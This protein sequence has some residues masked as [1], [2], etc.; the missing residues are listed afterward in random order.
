MGERVASL[1]GLLGSAGVRVV[2]RQIVSTVEGSIESILKIVKQNK[3]YLDEFSN[4]LNGAG[5]LVD[6]ISKIPALDLQNFLDQ[7]VIT[8]VFL[9]MRE[10]LG[11]GLGLATES[12]P[13]LSEFFDSV[14]NSCQNDSAGG[15]EV[16][17]SSCGIATAN[18][19]RLKDVIRKSVGK[20]FNPELV[21][22]I[23]VMYA[24]SFVC[25]N[26]WKMS[27]F[28][29]KLNGFA[30]N[31]HT[32]P[33]VVWKFISCLEDDKIRRTNLCKTFVEASVAVLLQLKLKQSERNFRAMPLRAMM[34]LVQMAVDLFPCV[35][36][37]VIEK[38][39]PFKLTHFAWSDVMRGRQSNTGD[40]RRIEDLSSRREAAGPDGGVH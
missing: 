28:N 22:L 14:L 38:C 11:Q 29:A 1:C 12:M 24:A 40:E 30:N 32:I 19:L 16:L 9:T 34:L 15:V 4:A 10:L 36:Q 18:D 2:Q 17:A 21:A 8:G 13:A 27:V 33:L 25:A 26:F 20:W 31:A 35:D 5:D 37:S 3:P 23:P 7:S 6:V 39:L